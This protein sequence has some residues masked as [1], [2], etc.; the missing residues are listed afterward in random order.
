MGDGGGRHSPR[1]ARFSGPR[2]LWRLALLWGPR[3]RAPLLTCVRL[4]GG[5]GHGGRQRATVVVRPELLDPHRHCTDA[6]VCDLCCRSAACRRLTRTSPRPW[7][8]TRHLLGQHVGEPSSVDFVDAGRAAGGD[9]RA[10]IPPPEPAPPPPPPPPTHAAAV[11]A[12]VD[13]QG[14]AQSGAGSHDCPLSRRAVL[15]SGDEVTSEQSPLPAVP[16]RVRPPFRSES[17]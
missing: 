1:T 16:S 15:R 11:T 7:R 12:R 9:R 8:S 4:R 17:P 6:K 13:T 3:P 14:H 2:D 5:C 10:L